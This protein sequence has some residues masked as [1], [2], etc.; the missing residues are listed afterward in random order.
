MV[1]GERF[2]A[3]I[4]SSANVNTNPR[5]ENTVI[6]V[7]RSLV[8]D[9]VNLFNGIVSFAKETRDVPVY[10]I[11]EDHHESENIERVPRKDPQ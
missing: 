10:Q 1:V 8:A 6:T 7:D 9:Y 11:Q 5:S 2:D 3:L 4:E